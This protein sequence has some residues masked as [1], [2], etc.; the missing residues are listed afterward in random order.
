MPTIAMGAM[1]VRSP[2]RVR[3]T[4]LDTMT[5]YFVEGHGRVVATAKRDYVD[6]QQ[7]SLLILIAPY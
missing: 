3:W 2:S 1:G 4:R 5:L 6:G 7:E